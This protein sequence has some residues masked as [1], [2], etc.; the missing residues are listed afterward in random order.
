MLMGHF[1][2]EAENVL[3]KIH[4]MGGKDEEI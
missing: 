4:W 3:A 2:N 1:V